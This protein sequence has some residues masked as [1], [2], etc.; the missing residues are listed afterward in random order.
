MHNAKYC[1]FFTP[2][3]IQLLLVSQ[4]QVCQKEESQT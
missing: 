3:L 1:K 4:R 2:T